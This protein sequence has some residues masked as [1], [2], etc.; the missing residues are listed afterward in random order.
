[1]WATAEAGQGCQEGH[2]ALCRCVKDTTHCEFSCAAALHAESQPTFA[3][4]EGK[5]GDA[6]VRRGHL[7]PPSRPQHGEALRVQL[8][9]RRLEGPAGH[10]LCRMGALPVDAGSA[11]RGAELACGHRQRWRR[12]RRR[13]R[14]QGAC[15]GCTQLSSSAYCAALQ[16]QCG[17]ARPPATPV[18]KPLL[19][20]A[21]R[22]VRCGCSTASTTLGEC[23]GDDAPLRSGLGLPRRRHRPP[24]RR[25]RR[26]QNLQNC[27]IT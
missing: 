26:A 22:F 15:S 6:G 1:M 7:L 12:G 27:S 4:G 9:E 17:H 19:G 3:G 20:F 18:S 13:R 14:L 10:P 23:K 11:E 24:A 2:N 8:A 21:A 5:G 16:S 25:S